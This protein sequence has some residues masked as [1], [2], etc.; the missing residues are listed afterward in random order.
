MTIQL[1]ATLTK[2][3][4]RKATLAKHL[5]NIKPLITRL[6]QTFQALT[7]LNQYFQCRERQTNTVD[8]KSKK[9]PYMSNF[10]LCTMI[11]SSFKPNRFAEQR[12]PLSLLVSFGSS[13]Y[14][15]SEVKS[16]CIVHKRS[17]PGTLF[18]SSGYE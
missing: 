16:Y 9:L 7:T 8:K 1:V 2:S 11:S 12:I 13:P 5:Q 10:C 4:L 3:C 18:V 15:S 14:H 6:K 17:G